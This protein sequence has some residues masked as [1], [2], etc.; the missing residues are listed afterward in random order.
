[1]WAVSARALRVSFGAWKIAR[2]WMQKRAAALLLAA[3]LTSI[4]GATKSETTLK[5]RGEARLDGTATLSDGRVIVSGLLSDETGRPVEGAHLDLQGISSP[6][7]NGFP[8]KALPCAAAGDAP[9]AGSDIDGRAATDRAGRFCVELERPDLTSVVLSFNDSRGLLDGVSRKLEVDRRRRGVELRFVRPPRLFD[10]EGKNELELVARTRP[11][12]PITTEPL[13]IALYVAGKP[14]RLIG[15][16]TTK[17]GSSVTIPVN[18]AELGPPGPIE[19]LARFPGSDS[20]QPAEAHLR[21]L[22]S[23]AVKLGLS[24]TPEPADPE[25][26]VV[27]D[28]A[29]GSSVGAVTSGSLEA[30]LGDETVGIAPVVKGSARLVARFARGRARDVTLTVR[31]LPAEPWWIAGEPLSVPV[32]L[33]P[34]SRWV[35]ALWLAAVTG[36]A[37]WLMRGWRRPLRTARPADR[38]KQP[39]RPPEPSLQ[40]LERARGSG[41]KGGVVD[42]HDGTP[43]QGASI[44]LLGVG[45]DAEHLVAGA[46]TDETGSFSLPG[47]GGV[48]TPL[49]IRITARL[50]SALTCPAPP[51]GRI[52]IA[53]VT[54][55]RNLLARLARWAD[56]QGPGKPS[57][58]PTPA[59]IARSA[60][61]DQRGNIADW[62]RAVEH[63]AFGPEAVDEPR[64]AHILA[65]EPE[66]V[67]A[68]VE[69]S[70]SRDGERSH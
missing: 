28:L 70:V 15:Q 43:I 13:P 29:L 57:L 51:E 68:E 25:S 17:S 11:A 22:R 65:R 33:L 52:A 42:A 19:V 47:A 69:G 63:A 62:A 66:D 67:P 4:A 48:K 44:E 55:R 41:W 59:Q 7:A 53:L 8:L 21:V 54:R 34:K 2:H 23:S 9:Q 24:Q 27:I 38:L 35:S 12:L 6:G 5:V 64:E 45:F 1:M 16:G 60:E 36:I 32:K 14:E 30:R 37:L 58:E 50:H 49:R 56:R 46:I 39:K 61:H 10:I 26:G 40:V 18:V 20:L 3:A 31:Y